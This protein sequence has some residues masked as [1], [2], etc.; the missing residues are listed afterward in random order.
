MV[1]KC[2]FCA[3]RLAQGLQPACVVASGGAMI[4]GDLEDEKSQVRESLP[5]VF[6]HPAESPS[7]YEPA[8][9]LYRVR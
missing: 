3:E 9:L 1:E 7:R 2:T 8:S 5:D 6:H 4:F